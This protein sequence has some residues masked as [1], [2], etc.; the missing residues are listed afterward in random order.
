MSRTD[1]AAR[2]SEAVAA[3]AQLEKHAVEVRRILRNKLTLDFTTRAG[4]ARALRFAL[5]MRAR[6]LFLR[7]V[8]ISAADEIYLLVSD[9]K[10]DIKATPGHCT[11]VRSTGGG[12][13]NKG[14]E[15]EHTYDAD[16]FTARIPDCPTYTQIAR[17]INRWNDLAKQMTTDCNSL[18]RYMELTDSPDYRDRLKRVMPLGGRKAYAAVL[19]M[20]TGKL[21]RSLADQHSLFGWHE[22]DDGNVLSSGL[23]DLVR[24]I[25][26]RA[27][28]RGGKAP[29]VAYGRD[30]LKGYKRSLAHYGKPTV[31]QTMPE[32]PERRLYKLCERNR[33]G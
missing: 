16:D 19:A 9:L 4:F 23:Y 33:G 27:L 8:F 5:G 3:V 32:Q 25:N 20:N 14:A 6:Y 18:V 29:S 10:E 24:Q 13:G 28:E 2:Y 21:D 15:G 7:G 1:L 11:I 22:K 30:I 31:P 26:P 12:W 17:L